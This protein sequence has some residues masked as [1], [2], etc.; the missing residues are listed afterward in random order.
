MNKKEILQSILMCDNVVGNLRSNLQNLTLIIPEI[1]DMIGFEHKHPHHHLDVWEHTLCALNYSPKNFDIRLILLLHDI[2]KPH[3]FQDNEVR[4]F[5]GHPEASAEIANKALERLNYNEK[6]I[7][8]ICK[9]I[10]RH[11]MPL[12]KQ[13]IISDRTLSKVIFTVQKC[14]AFA[15]NPATNKKRLEYIENTTKIFNET[16]PLSKNVL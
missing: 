15:H 2:G 10:A 1:S 3:S 7:N 6:Y 14:D 9:I 8:Y 5:K 11:D 13:E 12:T 4:H 16:K